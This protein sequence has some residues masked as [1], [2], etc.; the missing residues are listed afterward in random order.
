MNY[1]D[2]RFTLDIQIH[3]AQVSVPATFGDSARKLC[4]G[5]T[6]GRKPYVIGEGCRAV[7]NAKK[8]D[9]NVIKNDC[10]IERN[11]ILYEFTEQ[12][13]NSE[14]IVYCDITL[15]GADG[16][17]LTSPQFT[18]VVDKRVVRNG[19]V[20]IS[21]DQY[22]AL[23]NI[24]IYEAQRQ[25]AETARTE[26]EEA[27]VDAETARDNAEQARIEAENNRAVG[28]NLRKD[29]E[30]RR[31]EAEGARIQAENER[32]M[33]ENARD[34]A[35]FGRNEAELRRDGAE[36]DRVAAEKG[37]ADAEQIRISKETER[38]SKETE[39][40][41]KEAERQSKEAE[42]QSNEV[43]RQKAETERGNLYASAEAER[44]NLYASAETER[45]RLYGVAED[46]RG[47][48]FAESE[49][50]RNRL[51]GV[52]E[53]ARD[54]EF[55]TKETARQTAFNNAQAERN[56]EFDDAQAQR[57]TAFNNAQ[58]ERQTAFNDA[59]TQRQTAFTKE[60]N[61]RASAWDTE[62]A[63]REAQLKN[64]VNGLGIA[65]DPGDSESQ[66]MSQ[67]G[68]TDLA[69][70]I[71]KLD[72]VTYS[73]GIEGS[74]PSTTIVKILSDGS[75]QIT[76]APAFA[77]TDFIPVNE[78]T[79]IKSSEWMYANPTIATIVFYDAD[80]NLHSCI[81]NPRTDGATEY[82]FDVTPPEGA[83]YARLTFLASQKSH[84]I[85]VTTWMGAV[86][87]DDVI[88]E[89][90]NSK[91]KVMSQYGATK[92]VD[93]A[94]PTVATRNLANLTF[95]NAYFASGEFY[96]KVDGVKDAASPD[97]I[98]VKG[99]T[100]YKLSC[101]VKPLDIMPASINVGISMYD[102]NK[103]WLKDQHMDIHGLFHAGQSIKTHTDCR[104]IRVYSYAKSSNTIAWQDVAPSKLQIE[105]EYRTGYVPPIAIDSSRTNTPSV[106]QSGYAAY[107]LPILEFKGDMSNISK[108]N[109]VEVDCWYKY[110][111]YNAS[112]GIYDT[113]LKN[114][115]CTLKWQGS[116]S[117]QYPKKN[118]TV[119]FDTKFEAK[120]GW[121]EQ[122]KYCLKANYMDFSH[123]RNICSAKLWGGMVKNRT[124][125]N[126]KLNGLPNGGAI[127]GFPICLV[128]NGEYQGIYT[129]NIPKDKWMFGMGN[130]DKEAILCANE[131]PASKFRGEAEL[132]ENDLEIEYAPNEDDTDWIKKSINN[133]INAC[134]ACD[135]EAYF[136]KNIAPLLDVE[137]A[138]D[139]YI[140]CLLSQNL[141]GISRNYLLSTYDGTKWFFT[142]YDCDTVFGLYYGANGILPNDGSGEG[143]ASCS[144]DALAGSNRLFEIIKVY[145]PDELK[146][147]Y[148]NL[149]KGYNGA[150]GKPLTEDRFI[151]TFYNFIRKIPKALYDEEVK[152]WTTIPL[153]SVNNVSQI[154]DHYR[155][156]RAFI[157][158]QIEAL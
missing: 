10:I 18:I 142:A 57:Q 32:I 72:D 129:F 96:P 137:S 67:K 147:R 40:Q 92:L 28:E 130:G 87:E 73:P 17:V 102:E 109:E 69:K 100:S 44:G 95:E 114:E 133:L 47:E 124:V 68:A 146:A 20:V 7:F 115:K 110:Q 60:Q 6:D 74:C 97:Y 156:R 5:L 151:D 94:V 138:I 145:K 81:A 15:Y 77:T 51:Y 139:Y 132:T 30:D 33:Y 43:I 39:R 45:D 78:S 11:V 112:A 3:Q 29:A 63:S 101:D 126:E 56:S 117:L 50:E 75:Y 155:R 37:R 46:A 12:T 154:I 98:A 54:S 153:T 65:Q 70:M 111:K 26:A 27:R 34:A 58:T 88:H 8:P 36:L 89:S 103:T 55:N 85:R 61:D 128:I 82:T 140:F 19:E 150:F 35:E 14:G 59:Q 24:F 113:I 118:Y 23:D 9:G 83:K 41:N 80:K 158:P 122:K 76:T 31:G 52:A 136:D 38:Q 121:G 141:D 125:T 119:K 120:E 48:A 90:G 116:G 16:K 1:S 123:S 42:R 64:F 62:Y 4:I 22:T 79:T 108:E 99:D 84:W 144:L 93:D 71:T 91:E 104:Y 106:A 143:Y 131:S 134:I 21:E 127:D 2:Y 135:S 25:V 148:N 157:D 49:A 53:D 66:V 107:G 149:V 13:T 152:M 86:T 105:E